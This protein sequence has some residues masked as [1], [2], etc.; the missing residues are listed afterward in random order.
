M[1]WPE[2]SYRYSEAF[3]QKVIGEIEAGNYSIR[4]VSKLYKVSD[5]SLYNWLNK[6]GKNHLIGK[7]VKVEMKGEADRLKQLENEKK[8]LESALAQ[9]HLKILTLEST[10]EVAEEKY[11]VDFKKNFGSQGLKEV[12]RKK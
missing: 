12:S 8:A 3:K 2:I 1:S 4:Q 7:I 5:T 9:A 11:K 6:Y 10:I